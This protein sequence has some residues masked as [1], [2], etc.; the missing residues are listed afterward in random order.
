MRA[1]R[2][3]RR[4]K[5]ALPARE[6]YARLAATYPPTAGNPL[7][8]LDEAALLALLPPLAGRRVLDVGCGAGRY[9]RRL[10][11]AGAA[12]LVGCDP[13]AAMLRRTREA[14]GAGHAAPPAH[15]VRADVLALPFGDER[16]DVAVCGLVLGHVADLGRALGELARVL[17]PGGVALWSDVH[18]AGTLAGWVRELPGARGEHVRVVQHVHLF[19][20][21]LAACRAAGLELEAA[22]EPR[23][24][25][26]HPQR[27]WPAVLAL[28]AR[29]RG[30]QAAAR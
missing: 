20:D 1:W 19:A 28:R 24:A 30:G 5:P 16:F 11:A 13:V 27:G 26:A 15:L 9:L 22:R 3:W 29:K 8:E 21:H 17:A 10:H 2:F 23:I 14:G 25:F 12:T 7:M 6:A 18:P 4:P